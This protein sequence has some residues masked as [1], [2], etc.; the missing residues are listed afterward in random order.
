MY[1]VWGNI[2]FVLSTALW[3]GLEAIYPFSIPFCLV[4]YLSLMLV[5]LLIA[6][7]RNDWKTLREGTF[8]KSRSTLKDDQLAER[9][10]RFSQ[11]IQ[12]GVL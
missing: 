3:A 10:A 12:E 5:I 7:R 11:M 6:W 4:T 1:T 8:E 9:D 2:T